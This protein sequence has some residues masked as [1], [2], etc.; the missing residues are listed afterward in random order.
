MFFQSNSQI[1]DPCGNFKHYQRLQKGKIAL[2][3]NNI[4]QR[5]AVNILAFLFSSHNFTGSDILQEVFI[6]K[7][8]FLLLL[9][10]LSPSGPQGLV[11]VFRS[12]SAYL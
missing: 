8:I 10:E 11:V 3:P 7:Y 6:I 2:I 12:F 5:W 1:L 9:Y 4:F